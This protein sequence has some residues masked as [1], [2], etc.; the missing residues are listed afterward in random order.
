MIFILVRFLYTYFYKKL[1]E[2]F[3]IDL[4]A[5]TEILNSISILRKYKQNVMLKFKEIK[6]NEPKLPQKQI[7]NQP[8]F[9]DSTIKR[10]GDNYQSVKHIIRMLS[11]YNRKKRKKKKKSSTSVTQT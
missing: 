4:T 1:D 9:S 11:P 10:Y 6:S 7:C 5:E 3:T 2:Y 8:R